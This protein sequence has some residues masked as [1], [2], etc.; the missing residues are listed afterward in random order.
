MFLTA[1]TSEPLGWSS[2]GLVRRLGQG[3]RRR[4]RRGFGSQDVVACPP[5]GDAEERTVAAGTS[6]IQMIADWR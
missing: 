2:L 6:V 3:E 4:A 1:H 5:G